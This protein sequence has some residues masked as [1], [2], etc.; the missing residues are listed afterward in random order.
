MTTE[1]KIMIAI[2]VCTLGLFA[3]G[4]YW[5]SQVQNP[6]N[7]AVAT[8]KLITS[9]SQ[10]IGPTDAVVTLVEFGDYQCPSCGTANQAVKG[11]LAEYPDQLR[12]VFRHFPLTQHQ[13]STLAAQAAEAAGAQGKYWEM[14]NWLYENQALWSANANPLTLF[15]GAATTLGLDV[16]AFNQAIQNKTH[17]GTIQQGLADGMSIGVDSTPTFYINGKP[18]QGSMAQLKSAIEQNI[19]GSAK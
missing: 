15:S 6:A 2:G 16:T 14:H 19:G 11:L 8:E 13:H 9:E 5:M 3:G 4:I 12:F 10:S 18:F 7:V 17:S 1:L